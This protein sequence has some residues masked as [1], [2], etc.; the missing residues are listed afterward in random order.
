[1]DSAGTY[2]PTL[3]NRNRPRKLKFRSSCDTCSSLKIKCDQARPLCGRCLK[4]HTKCNYSPSRRKGKPPR[5]SRDKS[6]PADRWTAPPQ[7]GSIVKKMS[8]ESPKSTSD[9]MF[10]E[11]ESDLNYDHSFPNTLLDSGYLTSIGSQGDA[12]S[13]ELD[14]DKS[15]IQHIPPTSCNDFYSLNG[16]THPD[17][18]LQVSPVCGARNELF[19]PEDGYQNNYDAFGLDENYNDFQECRAL[20]STSTS[21]ADSFNQARDCAS[22]AN[23]TLHSLQSICGAP[24]SR[25]CSPPSSSIEQIIITNKSA[26]QDVQ[27]LLACPCSVD[28]HAALTLALICHKILIRYETITRA[29][30]P[31]QPHPL[32]SDFSFV[33]NPLLIPSTA[34]WY[35]MD[36]ESESRKRVQLVMKE[37]RNMKGLVDQFSQRYC[38]GADGAKDRDEGIYLALTVFLRSKVKGRLQDMITTLQSQDSCKASGRSA[39]GWT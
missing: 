23:A 29:T 16:W 1:M 5:I 28:P 2:G 17:A 19:L 37:L 8:F 25:H 34:D 15:S 26:I 7:D 4:T 31:P 33:E 9:D 38:A 35:I 12:S 3:T 10:M 30:S 21:S 24:L 20:L 39:L 18:T 11:M 27:R 36:M 22:T 13:P 14:F 6:S 32:S